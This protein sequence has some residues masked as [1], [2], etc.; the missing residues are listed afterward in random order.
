LTAMVQQMID[1][2]VTRGDGDLD[3]SAIVAAFD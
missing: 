3:H 1:T 2:L